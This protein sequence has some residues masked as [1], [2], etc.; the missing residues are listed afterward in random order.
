MI[1]DVLSEAIASIQ[2]YR[3]VHPDMYAP[4]KERLDSLVDSMEAIRRDLDRPPDPIKPLL[5]ERQRALL[6]WMRT[7]DTNYPYYVA[8]LTGVDLYAF[9]HDRLI[10]IAE[11]VSLMVYPGM[12]IGYIFS[13]DTDKHICLTYLGRTCDLTT[14]RQTR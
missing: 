11:I 1:S 7:S 3:N 13:S 9:E 5:N 6:E 8:T 2:S 4:Y 12:G 14:A 10:S